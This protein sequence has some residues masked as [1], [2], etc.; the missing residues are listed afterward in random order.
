[1]LFKVQGRYR[2]LLDK[3]KTGRN[4]DGIKCG[5]DLGKWKNSK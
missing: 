5:I 1:M 3:I 2:H 4:S